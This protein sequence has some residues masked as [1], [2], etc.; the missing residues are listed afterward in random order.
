MSKKNNHHGAN[1]SAG[2]NDSVT[3][4]GA[5]GARVAAESSQSQGKKGRPRPSSESSSQDNGDAIHLLR[6]TGAVAIEDGA[7]YFDAVAARVDL[8]GASVRLIINADLKIS[9]SELDR[10]REMKFGKT[11]AAVEEVIRV[12]PGDMPRPPR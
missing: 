5:A 11:G 8:V 3:G 1:G 2:A 10:V 7:A 12:E 9:K 4:S 6:R